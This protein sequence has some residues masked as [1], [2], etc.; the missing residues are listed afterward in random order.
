MTF[1][2]DNLLSRE[3]HPF[4]KEDYDFKVAVNSSINNTSDT[5]LYEREDAEK[6]VLESAVPLPHDASTKPIC[7]TLWSGRGSGKT[8]L[9]RLLALHSQKLQKQRGCGRIM[10]VDAKIL[11]P[12]VNDL[13]KYAVQIERV[14]PVLVALHL[15]KLFGDSS[16]K[17]VNFALNATFTSLWSRDKTLPSSL[18]DKLDQVKNGGQAYQWWRECTEE[19]TD[20][21]D[22]N[23]IIL[24][25]TAETL[26][27]INEKPPS[28][29]GGGSS[30]HGQTAFPFLASSKTPRH[31]TGTSS[32]SCE[33]KYL[34]LECL[35]MQIPNNNVMIAFGTGATRS[36][37]RPAAFQTFVNHRPIEPLNAL[38]EGSALQLFAMLK[39]KQYDTLTEQ[40]KRQVRTVF[41]VT[42][43]VPRMLVTAFTVEGRLAGTVHERWEEA[44]KDL[45]SDASEL[46][47]DSRLSLSC[48]AK[49]IL[50]CAVSNVALIADEKIPTEEVTW[51]DL[52]W[53]S[54]VF[55][56]AAESDA[57]SPTQDGQMESKG[58]LRIPRL[59]W[60]RD[61]DLHKELREWV[62]V[63]C[64][65]ALDDL[66]PTV[67]SLYDYA[68]EASATASG[69]P[70]EKMFASALVARFFVICWKEGENPAV[71]FVPLHTLLPQMNEKDSSTLAQ[72]EVCLGNGVNTCSSE[73][74]AVKTPVDGFDWTAIHANWNIQSAH[75]D[76]ILPVRNRKSKETALWAVSARNGHR[77]TDGELFATKQHLVSKELDEEVAGLI[78]AVNPRGGTLP[79]RRMKSTFANMEQ[80]QRYA[81]M[82][83]NEGHVRDV[84][85]C[86]P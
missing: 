42:A 71:H 23:P 65:F 66:L 34:V 25:D 85:C 3:V 32:V 55:L 26:S 48:L 64:H 79:N 5:I 57:E 41:A 30:L 68:G 35:M 33:E 50:I 38:S 62:H 82:S 9:I 73:T 70:W 86:F 72:I 74:L 29:I 67:L 49:A 56:S 39:E 21:D 36:H 45:Y 81:E 44:V 10:V 27:E 14:I 40:D 63:N 7:V 8:S 75:H 18:L 69:R 17:G 2:F 60:G 37:P 59:L 51:D 78:Q 13:K 15:C 12:I 61:S 6:L 46:V 77:K 47:S 43:G 58:H 16:V 53:R 24:M 1:L 20:N 4:R 19:M 84:L 22:P 83:I 52:R 11:L 54:I 76:L 28:P 31:H 80:E